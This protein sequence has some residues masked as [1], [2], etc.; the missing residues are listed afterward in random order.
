MFSVLQLKNGF[1][2]E[3][4]IIISWFLW[5]FLIVQPEG[6]DLCRNQKGEMEVL[7]WFFPARF[8]NSRFL[9]CLICKTGRNVSLQMRNETAQINKCPNIVSRL[10]V[11]KS[12]AGEFW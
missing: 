10:Y 11:F 12:S 3:Q 9:P 4:W 5:L 6:T 1:H 7:A 2:S 8:L